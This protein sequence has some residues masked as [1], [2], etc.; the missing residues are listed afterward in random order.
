MREI[1]A[2]VA[3]LAQPD[4]PAW[5]WSRVGGD[6]LDLSALRAARRVVPSD[7]RR[8]AFATWAVLG[9][10]ALDILCATQL[11]RRNGA[12]EPLEEGSG[13]RWRT[14]YKNTPQA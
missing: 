1:A 8:R 7:D 14:I 10:T 3:I 4:R 9:V 11:S 6:L 2:G 12:P 5:L 13:E